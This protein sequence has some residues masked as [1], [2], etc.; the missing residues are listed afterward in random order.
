MDIT[1]AE[2]IDDE[3]GE[4][5]VVDSP[6]IKLPKD[7]NNPSPSR[8]GLPLGLINERESFSSPSPIMFKKGRESVFPDPN[9][10]KPK[11]GKSKSPVD[12]GGESPVGRARVT[13]HKKNEFLRKSESRRKV[14][15]E[16]KSAEYISKLLKRLKGLVNLKLN[17]SGYLL[18]NMK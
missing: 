2:F 17:F 6:T 13:Q 7:S 16:N 12:L 5:P 11:L 14:K 4:S 10:V 8:L 18:R 15:L 1:I 9:M 3:D